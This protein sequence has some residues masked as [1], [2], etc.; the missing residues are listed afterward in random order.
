M[1]GTVLGM[2]I[3]MV[4]EIHGPFFYGA[5]NTAREVDTKTSNK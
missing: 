1:L 5:Y 3:T 4:N 2:E